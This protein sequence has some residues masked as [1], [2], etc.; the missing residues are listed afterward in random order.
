[1]VFYIFLLCKIYKICKILRQSF[2]IEVCVKRMCKIHL[3]FTIP[4]QLSLS[5]FF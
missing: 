4:P 1:M 2:M 5:S 3:H